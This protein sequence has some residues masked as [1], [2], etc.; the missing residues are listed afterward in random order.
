MVV[1]PLGDVLAEAGE[2]DETLAV[3]LM[4]EVLE[5]ARATNP[6]LANRRL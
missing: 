6:S 4:R 2:G 5:Q 3:T 1:D